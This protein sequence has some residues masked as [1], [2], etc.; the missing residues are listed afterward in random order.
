MDGISQDDLARA[1]NENRANLLALAARRLNPILLKRLSPED[2]LQETWLAAARRLDFFAERDDIP[3]YFKFR[4]IL[5][6]TITDIE[7]RNLQAEA[8]DAYKEVEVADD[9]DNSSADNRDGGL[10]WG[11][12]AADNTSPPSHLAREERRAILHRAIEAL[13]EA[14]R[15]IITLRHFDG[16]GNAECAAALGIAPKAA[17]IRHARALERLQRLLLE[18]STFKTGI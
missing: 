6:Q 11:M 13:T 18:Y 10:N 14:D 5:L 8:R 2:V 7:R 4:K 3:L 15:Q 12:F 1:F 16:L 9:P 17:S